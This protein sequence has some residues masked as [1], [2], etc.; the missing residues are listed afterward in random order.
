MHLRRRL[1]PP[2]LVLRCHTRRGLWLRRSAW[3]P[4]PYVRRRICISPEI[5]TPPIRLGRL[6]RM[7]RRGR[8]RTRLILRLSGLRRRSL[9]LRWSSPI[10]RPISLTR[11]DLRLRW[12]PGTN[13]MNLR[14]YWLNLIPRPDRR[15][16]RL[17]SPWPRTIL[18]IPKAAAHLPTS[19]RLIRSRIRYG[20]IRPSRLSR[21]AL[22]TA[23]ALLY[24]GRRPSRAR[25][26]C[27][28]PAIRNHRTCGHCRRRP[29]FVLV[30]ELL[31]VLRSL[32][33]H[34]DLRRHRRNPPLVHHG[35]LR[36]PRTHLQS[37]PSAVE[38][39]SYSRPLV[40][41]AMDVHIA[42]HVHVHA[43]HCRVV[44]E[45]PAI[46]VAAVVASAEVA[47]PIVHPAVEPDMQAP[48][49]MMEAIHVA[50]VS[51]VSWSPQCAH[52][53][54]RD[55]AARN[56][57]I[58]SRSPRPIS[59]RPQIIGIGS[60]RLVIVRQRR[61]RLVRLLIRQIARI[62]I[63][64]LR[65][66]QLAIAIVVGTVGITLIPSRIARVRSLA[67]N[68]RSLLLLRII[69]RLLL[70]LV[71][72][73]LP[74]N[75]RG[76]LIRRSISSHHVHRGW[77]AIRVDTAA[78]T[79]RRSLMTPRC[80][81]HQRQTQPY[82]QKSPARPPY[83]LRNSL[84]FHIFSVLKAHQSTRKRMRCHPGVQNQAKPEQ[85]LL[86]GVIYSLAS[87]FVGHREAPIRTRRH[88][89]VIPRIGPGKIRNPRLGHIVLR[90]V[91]RN[92]V[93]LP[94]V[95]QSG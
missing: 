78:R 39:D 61:R 53:R 89:Q 83:A 93:Q 44:E 80:A 76:W 84:C 25:Q 21:P 95:F 18:S 20:R 94:Q 47:K 26:L 72:R 8:R 86:C 30:E 56:P 27:R 10:L 85:S 71:L 77:V 68:R 28:Q 81:P 6:Y 54:S 36:N 5:R 70:A 60:G 88:L 14:L 41:L 67:F 33:T 23:E 91:R 74:Q 3:L 62:N 40:D 34:L 82:P 92:C 49:P 38:A 57:V 19:I 7:N 65:I 29:A 22:A 90:V 32:L 24:R 12:L 42:D 63:R 9:R 69:L 79:L 13:R 2:I 46:P 4:R 45:V 48:E 73:P 31:A 35:H 15:S 43:I 55:P 37:T 64:G 16:I 11:L 75:P 59:R 52:I 66:G 51:P 58:P 1:P 50:H 87:S 17:H